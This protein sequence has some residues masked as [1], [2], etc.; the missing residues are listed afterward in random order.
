MTFQDAATTTKGAV[1]PS[2]SAMY[3]GVK[4]RII[5]Q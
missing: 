1:W 3:A 2:L 5:A 4:L